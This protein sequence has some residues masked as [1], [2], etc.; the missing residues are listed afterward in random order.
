MEEISKL[1]TS[2]HPW[3][4]NLSSSSRACQHSTV[5]VSIHCLSPVQYLSEEGISKMNQYAYITRPQRCGLAL[6]LDRHRE[7]LYV[8]WECKHD[9]VSFI[10]VSFYCYTRKQQWQILLFRYVSTFL[11]WVLQY[12]KSYRAWLQ[13][14]CGKNKIGTLQMLQPNGI[15]SIQRK[16]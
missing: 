15:Q 2:A 10:D 13:K 6:N 9:F 7:W 16:T 5:H 3:I 1:C 12:R 14:W 11:F 4:S 8:F